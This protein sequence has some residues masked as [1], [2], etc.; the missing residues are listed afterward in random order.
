[1][2]VKEELL[3]SFDDAWSHKWESFDSAMNGLT[4]EEARYQSPIYPDATASAD[5]PPN[6]T[7]LWHLVHLAQ[8]Y[9]DYAAL[10]IQRPSRPPEPPPPQ[11]TSVMEAIDVAKRSRAALRAAIA[12]LSESEL[13]EKICNGETLTEFIRTRTRHD[14]WHIAQMVVARRLYKMRTE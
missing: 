1:M 10:I 9:Q 12:T 5:E 11:V 2:T 13:E 4:D 7:I 3:A 6:G 14:T 8:C